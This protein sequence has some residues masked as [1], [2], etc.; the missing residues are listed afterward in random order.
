MLPSSSAGWKHDFRARCSYM[1]FTNAT[2]KFFMHKI[3][4]ICPLTTRVVFVSRHPLAQARGSKAFLSV[5]SG[6]FLWLFLETWGWTFLF[7]FSNEVWV[8]HWVLTVCLI[9]YVSSVIITPGWFTLLSTRICVDAYCGE[10]SNCMA[11]KGP[12]WLRH[13]WCLTFTPL[14][15]EKGHCYELMTEQCSVMFDYLALYLCLPP[16]PT[17]SFPGH[18]NVS[19]TLLP[20]VLQPRFCRVD[21]H[22]A[23]QRRY[24]N[25]TLT[26]GH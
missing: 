13:G 14:C 3:K 23:K 10:L 1:G 11:L 20:V 26:L 5:W 12:C 18:W 2:M 19:F 4:C 17:F 6:T 7:S 8:P 21:S 16:P 25:R 22:I 15:Q 24:V 9:P